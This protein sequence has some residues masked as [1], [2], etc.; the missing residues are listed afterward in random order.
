MGAYVRREP[1]Q[2]IARL[3]FLPF[4]ADLA[5]AVGTDFE[6]FAETAKHGGFLAVRVGVVGAGDVIG[7][8]ALFAVVDEVVLAQERAQA[9]QDLGID[10]GPEE[11][12][13]ANV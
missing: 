1:S 9:V 12:E 13:V 4:T 5:Q 2:P 10:A 11:G 6:L 8:L 3:G 7:A